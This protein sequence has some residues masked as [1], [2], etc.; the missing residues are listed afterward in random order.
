MKRQNSKPISHYLN[1]DRSNSSRRSD[2]HSNNPQ[3]NP[4]HSQPL[5]E[6]ENASFRLKNHNN[7]HPAASGP[8]FKVQSI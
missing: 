8:K 2:F 3:G 1:S 4:N 7:S 6:A 5:P